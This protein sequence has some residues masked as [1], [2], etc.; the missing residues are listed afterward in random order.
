MK[1]L[2]LADVPFH[3]SGLS[4]LAESA[5]TG[6][7]ALGHNVQTHS[8]FD[9]PGI[10]NLCQNNKYDLVLGVGYWADA[11]RQISIPKKYNNKVALWWVSESC[12]PKFQ[13]IILQA[14]LFLATSEY[15]K[16]VFEK[17]VPNSKPKVLYPGVDTEFFKPSSQVKPSKIFSTFVSSGEIKGCDE[18]LTSINLLKPKKLDFKYIIHSPHT[19]YKLE[20][21]YMLRLQR[22]IQSNNLQKWVSL[23][24][25]N[26]LS[27]GKIP[28]LYQT[29]W[30]Y[31]CSMRM[32][33]FGYPI[34]ESGACG[35]PTIA[36]DW[37]PMNE[38]IKDS[39]TGILIPHM[40]QAMIPKYMEGVWFPEYYR[41]IDVEILAQKIEELLFDPDKR[42]R[43]G[44]AARKDVIERFN[45]KTQIKKLEEELLKIV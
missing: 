7:T 17:Y 6:L 22:I 45:V 3:Q 5:Y 4:I 12:V 41:M 20:H 42:N 30:F 27:R 28:S 43:L 11:E 40:A 2:L 34:A 14:D 25:G 23:L 33:C 9:A 38:I 35:T 15:S 10:N 29:M 26:K 19:E 16:E 32:G 44:E 24:A 8:L 37:K 21:D 18:V 13:D 36:G 39:E 31:M 1:I